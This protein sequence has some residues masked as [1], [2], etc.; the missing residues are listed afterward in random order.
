MPLISRPTLRFVDGS[1]GATIPSKW[2]LAVGVAKDEVLERVEGMTAPETLQWNPTLDVIAYEIALNTIWQVVDAFWEDFKRTEQML[3][4]H[5]FTVFEKPWGTAGDEEAACWSPGFEP[6]GVEGATCWV[7]LD[8]LHSIFCRL[9]ELVVALDND[10]GR[11]RARS[12]VELLTE[13]RHRVSEAQLMIVW[14]W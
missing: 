14:G 8:T 9:S 10:G 6:E 7:N 11:D 2:I 1:N 13:H 3:L 4:C 12:I 5:I